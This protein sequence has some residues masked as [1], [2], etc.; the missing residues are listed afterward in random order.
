[1][2]GLASPYL[3]PLRDAN[4]TLCG[5]CFASYAQS[6]KQVE[7]IDSYND[8]H[9]PH[10]SFK[11]YGAF[12]YHIADCGVLKRNFKRLRTCKPFNILSICFFSLG[13]YGCHWQG[14]GLESEWLQIEI[15]W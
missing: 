12:L 1:M 11:G 3:I 13:A 6:S 7:D 10:S 4:I 14:F 2:G 15:N 5:I 9:C 8:A